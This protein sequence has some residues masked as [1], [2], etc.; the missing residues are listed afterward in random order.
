MT[1]GVETVFL[2][3]SQNFWCEDKKLFKGW[4]QCRRNGCVAQLVEWSRLTP[5]ISGSD[6]V[7]GNSIYYQ[8]YKLKCIEKANIYNGV[9]SIRRRRSSTNY[10]VIRT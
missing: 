4:S 9:A 5:E 2:S 6:P 7:I 3:L 8:R 1:T 10:V